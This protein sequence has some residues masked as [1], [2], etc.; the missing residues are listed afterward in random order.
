MSRRN[1]ILKHADKN[2]R[3]IELGPY[4]SPLASKRDG[5]NCLYLDVFDTQTI[6]RR[7][8]ADP[9]LSAEQAAQVES[10]DLV[11]D[12]VRID[13]L[14][15]DAGETEPFDYIISANNFEHLPN[16]IKFLQACGRVLKTGGF[17]SIVVPDKSGCLDFYRPRTS[18]TAWIEAFFEDRKRPTCAQIFEQ[19]SMI[20]R[21]AGEEASVASFSFVAER[22]LRASF[23]DWARKRVE[24]DETYF[25]VHC[26]AF[27]PNSFRLLLTDA[28]FLGLSP[29]IVEEVIDDKVQG[30][31][32][33]HLRLD[34]YKTFSE[35]ETAAHYARR[36]D[37]LQKVIEDEASVIENERICQIFESM[38]QRYGRARLDRAFAM[39][40]AF[41]LLLRRRDVKLDKPY[42]ALKT[43]V[44][45]DP[46]VYAE[47][48]WFA[49]DA[50]MHYLLHGA[51]EGLDP[52]P[53][54]STNGYLR[55]NPDVAQSGMN[56]LAHYELFGRKEGRKPALR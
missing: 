37:I 41:E 13:E 4:F 25:D 27:T 18:L 45:F 34:S 52:G 24:N 36:Q 26:S 28:Y 15:R 44:L 21:G 22:N 42:L 19:V 43:S 2:A 48:V 7:A 3:G 54:F 11:G 31:F 12:A 33:A 17:L 46:A 51:N 1:E 16:P 32:Y 47:R 9:F 20:A 50:A 53:F 35:P 40:R 29:F 5:Y 6:R 38:S 39:A 55:Q 30:G 23:E 8:A 10:V 14:C 49:G 56:P